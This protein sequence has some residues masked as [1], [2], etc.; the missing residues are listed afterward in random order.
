VAP[1][2]A[3]IRIAELPPV[4]DGQAEVR[5]LWSAVSRGTERLVFTGAVSPGEWARMR[6]PLQEGDFPFPV[7]YGYAAVG[8]VD[9]GPEALRGRSVFVLHPHQ[10][11][12]VCDV[13]WLTPL[14]E[15]LPV[16]RAVLAANMETALNAL[17]DAGAGP[18]DRIVVVGAGIVGLLVTWLAARLPGAEVTAV[19]RLE[20]RRPLVEAFGARFS[21]GEALPRDADIVF[22]TS[23][24]E[25]GLRTA[26][27]CCEEAMEAT[28]VELSWY[29]S[30]DVMIPLGAVFH[31]QRLKILSS[32]V[33][34][35]AASRRERW[36]YARR[37]A[38]AIELLA[39]DRLDALLGEDTAFDAL[40]AALPGVM[41]P[42]ATALT[43]VVRYG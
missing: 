28:I 43:A 15:T 39:D 13:S 6:C 10:D 1:G 11:R 29:G 30:R 35:V 5:T 20:A 26:L 36:P 23:A 27:S 33:G 21:T 8:I 38:K 19:D 25:A 14:P 40:P 37:L 42:E 3:D 32:Q 31:S 34:K 2:R 18:G 12:F 9:D 24:S 41:A 4:G 16:R 7:K 17:W 22:H